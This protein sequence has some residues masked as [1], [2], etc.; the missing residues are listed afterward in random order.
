[1]YWN[2]SRHNQQ[3]IYDYNVKG[4]GKVEFQTGMFKTDIWKHKNYYFEGKRLFQEAGVK[5]INYVYIVGLP[6]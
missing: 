2:I 4:L 1:M 3:Q 5:G 6:L